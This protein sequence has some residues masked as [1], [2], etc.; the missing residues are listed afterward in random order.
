MAKILIEPA[1]T[2]LVLSQQSALEN[3]LNKLSQEVDN[4]RGAVRYK[5]AGQ[6]N[7]VQCLR[8]AAEQIFKESQSIQ[9]MR[10][11][12]EQITARYEQTENGN[13]SR[14]VAEQA[15]LQNGGGGGVSG[16]SGGNDN[17][18]SLADWLKALKDILPW[19]WGPAV[20]GIGFAWPMGSILGTLLNPGAVSGSAEVKSGVEIDLDDALEDWGPFK[21]L[22]KFTDAHS[23]KTGKMLYID[24]KTGTRTVVDPNDKNAVEEFKKHNEGAIPVDVK[25]WGIG[26][27]G[28][29]AAWNP[30]GT[31]SGS[32]WGAEGEVAVSKL[33]GEAEAHLGLLGIGASLGASYTAFSAS[34]KAYLGSEDWNLYEEVKVEAGR[35]GVKGEVN[36]GLIDKEGNFNPSAYGGFEAEAIAG[37]ISGKVGGNIGGMV[38]VGLE[39]SLNYGL[40]AHANAGYHDGKISLDLG[41]TVGVGASVKLEIDISGAVNA[42]GEAADNFVSGLKDFFSW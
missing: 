23:E 9:S 40:G 20:P 32:F 31:V 34:E 1:K 22:D 3:K 25:V 14:I 41:V 17:E 39:G 12:L 37:E 28:S 4:V 19:I 42:F 6:Q 36:F 21:K 27:T 11:G 8:E 15:S 7:I 13:I 26:A 2:K 5:I 29:I 16:P 24:P 35:L 30:K 38:D 18:H 33:E 10:S